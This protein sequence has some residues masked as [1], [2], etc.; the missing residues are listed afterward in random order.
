[1]TPTDIMI[2]P[3][4]PED[5]EHFAH[6]LNRHLADNGKGGVYF[7]PLPQAGSVFSSANATAFR[8][9]LGVELG[10]PGWRRL[11]GAFTQ[12]QQLIGHID[13]RARPEPYASHRCLLGMGVDSAW[14]QQGL[15]R[16]LLAHVEDWARSS[17]GLAWIDLQVLSVNAPA[18]ALYRR[19]GFSHTGEVTQMFYIDGQ[20]LDYTSM[21][22]QLAT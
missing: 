8:D 19:A 15:G 22:K 6:Y 3:I 12:D 5:F 13:L 2:A 14:R 4:G 18:L 9:A 10:Q 21:S 11:W 20:W 7:Q 16:R 17:A 1:M